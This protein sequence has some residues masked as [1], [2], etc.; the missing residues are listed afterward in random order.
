VNVNIGNIS[1][2]CSGHLKL[3]S[4]ASVLTGSG[5]VYFNLSE[6]NITSVFGVVRGFNGLPNVRLKR[7][8]TDISN[9][10]FSIGFIGDSY[11]F[12]TLTKIKDFILKTLLEWVQGE[13][14]EK[15]KGILEKSINRAMNDT[16][17]LIMINNTVIGINYGLL[18]SPKITTH[19][20]LLLNGT[21]DC[22]DPKRCKP[23]KGKRPNPPEAINP[24]DG[25]G[26]LIALVSDYV[27]NTAVI[28]GLEEGL[29][30]IT[31]TSEM[32]EKVFGIKLD[33]NLVGVAVP[34][35]RKAYGEGKE[36]II[37]FITNEVP[38][39]NFSAVKGIRGNSFLLMN[40]KDEN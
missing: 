14:T 29:L 33:T 4:S 25:S 17:P 27:L 38:S 32:V 5:P 1:I 31:V 24:F 9:N 28:A 19:L 10:S 6:L 37:E 26:S 7:I 35:I 40:R 18:I 23:Y 39:F 20:P 8:L 12:E 11:I 21:V 15:N 13:M 34:E 22:T 2:V 30:N 3:V 16:A 36:V